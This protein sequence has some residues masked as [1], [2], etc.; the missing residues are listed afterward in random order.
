[1]GINWR[2]DLEQ[3]AAPGGEVAGGDV[4]GGGMPPEF[5][6]G[7]A[8]VGVDAAGEEP[9]EEPIEEPVA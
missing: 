2:D 3:A 8:D 9:I 4:A 6:G 5:G 1:M 7:A